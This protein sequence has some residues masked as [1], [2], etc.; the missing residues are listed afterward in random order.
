MRV[1]RGLTTR[2][3]ASI[4]GKHFSLPDLRNAEGSP[5]EKLVSSNFGS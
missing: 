4:Q 3:V 1:T 2:R 5:P